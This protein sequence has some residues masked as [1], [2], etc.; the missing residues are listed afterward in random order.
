MERIR[1][2]LIRRN[3]KHVAT[4]L[5]RNGDFEPIDETTPV[6]IKSVI[7][8]MAELN[9]N[10]IV[11]LDIRAG[12][13]REGVTKISSPIDS[14]GGLFLKN[15][16]IQEP[17]IPDDITLP[18]PGEETTVI[19]FKSDSWALGEFI[20]KIRTGKGIPKRFLKSQVLLDKFIGGEDDD[21]LRKLLVIDPEKRAYTW[22]IA[23]NTTTDEGCSLM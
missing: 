14:I 4:I 21:V 13:S 15:E 20:L 2:I 1:D 8:G 16:W 18:S 17:V 5:N 10:G 3:L 22:E 6:N 11:L 12:T 7:Q 19:P 23:E 9:K